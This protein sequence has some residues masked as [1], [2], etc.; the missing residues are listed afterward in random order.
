[1]DAVKLDE[2]GLLP[3]RRTFNMQ[4]EWQ[5]RRLLEAP[6]ALA[7]SQDACNINSDGIQSGGSGHCG[8]YQIGCMTTAIHTAATTTTSIKIWNESY[9]AYWGGRPKSG[10]RADHFFCNIYI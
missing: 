8:F 10:G 2:G 5:V 9:S 4:Q 7:P 1:V 3:K 6:A